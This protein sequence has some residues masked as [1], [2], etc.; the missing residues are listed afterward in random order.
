MKDLIQLLDEP[1]TVVAV[2]GATDNAAKYGSVA[3]RDLRAKGFTVYPVN[4]RRATVAG[5]TAYPDLA[6]LPE[7]P[8]IVNYVIPP[9]Q[10]LES[11]REAKRLGYTRVWLQPGAESPEVLTYLQTEGFEYLANACIMVQSRGRR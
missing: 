6:S 8:T 1:D 3:Y 9:E 7:P 5:D 10:A 2:V 11:L 4:S